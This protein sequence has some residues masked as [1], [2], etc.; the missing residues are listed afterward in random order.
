MT[1]LESI[2]TK[3]LMLLNIYLLPF[4][5]KI[6]RWKWLTEIYLYTFKIFQLNHIVSLRGVYIIWTH[7]ILR[8]LLDS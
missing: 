7:S 2:L 4:I 1:A 6:I 3:F 5:Y 8:L